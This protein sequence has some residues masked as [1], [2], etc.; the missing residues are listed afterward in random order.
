MPILGIYASSMQPALN[1]NSY[2]SIATATPSGSLIV[3]FSSIPSTY[4]HLQLRCFYKTTGSA[5]NPTLNLN[6]DSA[7]NYNGHWLFGTG[8]SAGAST[9]GSTTTIAGGW[10]DPTYWGAAIY[11]ILDY[12]NTNK[13]KTVRYLAGTDLNGGGYVYLASGLWMNTSAIN[14]LDF[15]A[16]TMPAGT[17]I[18]LYGVK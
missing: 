11:D 14:R 9:Q 5:N 8:T 18:A 12:T 13:Y 10:S 15:S 6:N 3:T 17:S 16:G 1:A 2:E 7:A 4:K